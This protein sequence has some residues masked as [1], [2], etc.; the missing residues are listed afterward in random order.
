MVDGGTPQQWSYQ[1]FV[2][3]T[4]IFGAQLATNMT[5]VGTALAAINMNS[6]PSVVSGHTYEF[7]CVLFL[8][9]GLAVDGIKID[10]NGGGAAATTFRAHGSIYGAT[11]GFGAQVTS[12]TGTIAGA[13]ITTDDEELEIHGYFKPSS[14]GTFIPR[15]AKNGDA[16]GATLTIYAGSSIVLHDLP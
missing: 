15:F 11:S 9:E 10:F 4:T 2:K 7:T 14:S 1:S 6:V 12:L 8:N 13:A 5:T 16:A 3:T